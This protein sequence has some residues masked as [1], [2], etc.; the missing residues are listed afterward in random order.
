ML[1]HTPHPSVTRIDA[2]WIPERFNGVD[3]V[4][5]VPGHEN[6]DGGADSA[7]GVE[8][9][10]QV[11]P[12]LSFGLVGQS[13][14]SRGDE[15]SCC[16]DRCGGECVGLGG[17]QVEGGDVGLGFD[18]QPQGQQATD[19]SLGQGVSGEFVPGE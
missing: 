12:G 1:S 13:D 6:A 9:G 18:R 10:F 3:F 19:G 8:R 17:I 11:E 4:D 14:R 7:V 5:E 16:G 2:A 15:L